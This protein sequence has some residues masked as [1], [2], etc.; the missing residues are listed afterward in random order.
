MGEQLPSPSG[1]SRPPREAYGNGS[2]PRLEGFWQEVLDA[3]RPLQPVRAAR[4]VARLPAP[5]RGPL[6][7]AR[8]RADRGSVGAPGRASSGSARGGSSPLRRRGAA[9]SQ[10]RPVTLE[11]KPLPPGP[12][13][14]FEPANVGGPLAGGEAAPYA[15]RSARPIT[16]RVSVTGD[17]NVRALSPPSL[18]AFPGARA[19]QPV[20]RNAVGAAR[21]PRV[22]DADRRDGAGA[23]A[24]G[25]AGRSRRPGVA[26]LR[27]PHRQVPGGPYRRAQGG[28]APRRPG[29]AGDG[30]GQQS[31]G[32]GH[33]RHPLAGRRSRRRRAAGLAAD[34]VPDAP[35]PRPPLAS[36]RPRRWRGCGPHGDAHPGAA[37]AARTARRRIAA[38]RRRLARGDPAGAFAE[39]EHGL[40]GYASGRLGR[41]AAGLTREELAV[42]LA[43]A[44]AHPPADPARWSAPWTWWTPRATAPAEEAAATSRCAAAER[45][46]WRRWKRRTGSPR[47]RW[48]RDPARSPPARR[49]APHPGAD[50]PGRRPGAGGGFRP[51]TGAAA[52][53]APVPSARFEAANRAYL[54]GDFEAAAHGYQELLADGWESPALYVNLGNA[55]FRIGPA[56]PGR[57]QLLA[58]AASSTRATPTRAPTWTCRS[59]NVDQVVGAEARPLALRALDRVPDGWARGRVRRSPGWGCGAAWPAGASRRRPRQGAGGGR[60]RGRAPGGGQRRGAGGQGRR[61]RSPPRP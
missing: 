51:L 16:V 44:G 14:G 36:L 53:P 34:L 21:R 28:G 9:R 18:P 11:V 17:G 29:R 6:P 7:D 35:A 41:P 37:Q 32:G 49:R 48:A 57:R 2:P 3:P 22:R 58:R 4:D 50:A 20:T 10:E 39:L 61:E 54:A 38:A 8:R 52:S 15:S 47:G 42:E 26:L 56:R 25:R 43:R 27:P 1:C 23:R 30:A 24:R 59:L 33:P 46:A 60:V 31:A 55:R 19:F 45:R 12:P 40:L 5:A 13:P